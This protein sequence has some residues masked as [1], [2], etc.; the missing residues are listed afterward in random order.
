MSSAWSWFVIL[1]TVL[2]LVGTLAFLLSNRSTSGQETTGHDYDGIQE[3][4]NPLPLWWVSMFIVSILF[5]GGYLIYYP[6]LGNFSGLGNWSSADQVA[7]EQQAHEDRFAPLYARLAQLDEAGLHAD[8]QA[9]Q[10]GRRLF[11]NNCSTC[12]GVAGQGAFG[13]PNLTDDEWIWGKGFDKVKTAL[14]N[15][16]QAAMPG[17]AA[18][19][20]DQGVDDVTQHVLKLAGSEHNPEAAARG[21]GQYAMFCVACHG[22]EGSGNPILGAPNLTND[23]WL[24]GGTAEAIAFTLRHGRNGNMPSFARVLDPDRIHILAGYV[25]SLSQQ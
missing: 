11:I 18:A 17:W 14:Q 3:L 23:I 4:D 25:T 20:G 9:Q 6:G 10:V 16:R 13:F 24:Y 22:P 12:H 8:R 5:A 19:L 7:R 15:G 21:A 2:S 1:G